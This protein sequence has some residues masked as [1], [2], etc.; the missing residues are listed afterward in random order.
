[1]EKVIV[2]GNCAN[3]GQEFHGQIEIIGGVIARVGKK[4]GK[5]DHVFDDNHLIFPGMGDIHIHAREDEAGTQS[6]KE[7]Y[8]T[9]TAAAINGGVVQ[10]AAMPNTPQPLIT[11]ERLA[12]HRNRCKD[13]PVSF[14]H[15]AGIGPGTRPLKAHVPYKVYTGPSIGPLFF[16]SE[17]ELR[18]ALQHYKGKPVSFHV[19]DYGVLVKN[20]GRPTHDKRRPVE[21]VEAALGYVLQMIEEFGLDAKLCHWPCGGK[22]FGMIRRHR[23]RGFRTTIEGSPLH[24][25]FDTDMLGKKPEL[26]PYVQMNPALQGKRH[27]LQLIKA[28]K[29]GFIDFLATDHAP[30]TLDEKFRNFGGE[31][32]YLRLL[33]SDIARCREL[34]C[35]NGTSGTTQLDTYALLAAWLM[36]EHG[37]TPKDIARVACENPGKF[38]NRFHAGKG[39]FGR[40]APGYYGSLTV[41][42]M[43][44]PTTVTRQMLRTKSKWSPYEG[45]TFPGSVAMV[46]IK[47]KPVKPRKN[48]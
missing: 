32:E 3:A 39:K 43:K 22:S 27:R 41:L 12:W 16:R 35:R 24:L 13:L 18:Q 21:C 28:L 8:G 23:K 40:I 9:V 29:E 14:V 42:N 36:E 47:G 10:V 48:L 4:L 2:E 26:W 38:A 17:R 15:Y 7:D 6:Y 46:M 30:H 44:K 25:Y 45:I 33:K 20:G 34:S 1:M 37:F 5:A 11:D 31:K 19:E